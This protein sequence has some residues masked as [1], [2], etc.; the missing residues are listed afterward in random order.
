MAGLTREC[1]NFVASLC[2]EDLPPRAVEAARA[3]ILDC[4]GV[5]IAGAGEEAVQIVSSMVSTSLQNDSAPQLPSG[6]NLTASDAA[7]VNGVAAHILDYDDVALAG[8][9]SAVLVPA[10]LAEGWRQNASG[11]DV[12]TAYAAGYEIWAQLAALEPGQYHDRGFHPT[13]VLGTLAT[14]AACANLRRLDTKQSGQAIGIAASLSSG[15]VA[16]FG[17]MTKS[18]HAGRAA[19]SGVIAAELAMR[20]YTASLDVL[21]HATG[22]M[23]A[24]SPSGEARSCDQAVTLGE[25]WALAEIGVNLKRYPVCYATHRAVDAMLNLVNEHQF[26]PD[27]IE[28]IR[29]RTGVTQRLMLRNTRPGTALEAKFSMEFALAAPVVAGRLGLAELN[30]SFVQSAVVSDTIAK[31]ICTTTDEI[32]P[33]GDQPYAPDDRVSVL[34][35]SGRQLEHPPVVHA[36]GSWVDPMTRQEAGEKFLDCVLATYGA[37]R[38]MRLFEQLWSLTELA[39]I[40]KLDIIS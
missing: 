16:N 31:V 36:R 18:L 25:H 14:A 21:E 2:F 38:G 8:H 1:G 20:G 12:I 33:G 40:R 39:S 37:P 7:L 24:F 17:S 26:K 6:R 4:V 34:L 9:P 35:K 28:E 3:G 5:L 15:L 22:F 32:V 11:R 23:N 19:Q 29:V 13:S 30:D 27:E 10:L